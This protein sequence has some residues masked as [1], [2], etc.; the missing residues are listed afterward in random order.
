MDA[1]FADHSPGTMNH[2]PR[3]RLLGDFGV[4]PPIFIPHGRKARALLARLALAQGPLARD[5]LSTLLWSRRADPQAHASLRQ[6]LIELK[7]WTRA[8][9]PLIR[10][11]RDMVAID[12]GQVTDDISLLRA[13]C[14]AGDADAALYWL[15]G[16]E[17]GLLADLDGIDEAWDDWLA[18]E[19]A[20]QG[21]AIVRD[22][23]A[24]AE[25]LLEA[26]SLDAAL[27]VAERVSRFDP[28]SERAARLIM[29]ARWRA[30][31][32][33]GVRHAWQRIEGAIARGLDGR[34]APE[35][36]ALYRELMAKRPP[37]ALGLS[38]GSMRLVA[39]L[40]DRATRRRTAALAA[41]ITIFSLAAADVPRGGSSA[42]AL[43]EPVVRIESVVSRGDDAV[44]KR[45]ADALAGDFVRLA[46]AERGVIRVLDGAAA[47]KGED[48]VVRVA[49]ER[50]AGLLVSD[51]RI[52]DAPSG[53][54]LW[55]NRL[56]GAADDVA[57]LR[58][59]TAV[60]IAAMIDCALTLNAGNGASSADA[61]RRALVFATCG[62]DCEDDIA[63]T[64]ALLERMN[65][66]WPLDS[67]ILGKL[68]MTR[69]GYIFDTD[70]PVEREKRRLRAVDAA[71][72]ALAIDPRNTLAIVAS[73]T[74]GKGDLYMVDG[75][76]TV[77]RALAIDPDFSLALM[78]NATGLFQAGFVDASVDP[79]IRAAKADPSTIYKALGVIRRL[80]AA[81]RLKEA[82]VRL[83]EVEAIWPAHP[84]L[85]EHRIRLAMELG[86]KDAL[87]AY[88][89]AT[90]DER[91]SFSMRLLGQFANR[92]DDHQLD[93]MIEAEFARS[94]SVAYQLAAHYTR[95]GDMPRA[96]D[97]LAR[98]PVRKTE[99]QWSLLYWPSVAP[100][101]QD[102]RFFA[103]MARLGLVD[104][105]RT[106]DRWP[107][108]CREPGL[109]YDCRG[110][111]E[112]LVR[113]AK[114]VNAGS[115]ASP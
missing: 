40:T 88:R 41:A 3:L 94:P 33:D 69:S 79:A 82:S 97:W 5:R 115:A 68:A 24:M 73:A 86:R 92:D 34:P 63:R 10:A 8:S 99:G 35:T 18:V 91:R 107:D 30:G 87:A 21:D 6:C 75:L 67:A 47:G 60:S 46:N 53:S 42:M 110:E 66:R 9:P 65:Q 64:I 109:R 95:L 52:V 48:F 102:R 2:A 61:D 89:A 58:E 106:R 76:P 43:A 44:E 4:E 77:G 100:L 27:A 103:K 19:R 23:L 26:A 81:G 70:D 7:S 25:R 31:D 57:R 14:A 56:S 98:A 36:A 1:I 90:P 72:N 45:F 114:A 13:A 104:Y 20:R 84:N 108:F 78:L 80:A 74:T 50:D 15:P 83:A 93:A 38:V 71:R 111:A 112:R 28:C 16:E 37:P 105:W 51:S 22:V 59:R 113:V 32:D 29:R 54:I 17:I 85:A 49:I 101:R 12:H 62:A 39:P 96:L 11:D 55:S